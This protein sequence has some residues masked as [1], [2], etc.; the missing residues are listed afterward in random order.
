MRMWSL[1]AS[2]GNK[3]GSLI[4]DFCAADFQ[5]TGCQDGNEV[6]D[7]VENMDN[8]TAPT[9]F[10]REEAEFTSNRESNISK[11]LYPKEIGNLVHGSMNKDTIDSISEW[12]MQRPWGPPRYSRS[13][14]PPAASYGN[15]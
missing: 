12:Y 10:S 8:N 9:R 15:V 4:L 7:Q 1:V 11:T 6:L 2:I 13:S 14:T 5:Q 3:I